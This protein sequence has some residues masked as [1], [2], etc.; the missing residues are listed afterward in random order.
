L[1][2]ASDTFWFTPQRFQGNSPLHS[3]ENRKPAQL[4]SIMAQQSR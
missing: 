4:L 3:K 1:T 2:I